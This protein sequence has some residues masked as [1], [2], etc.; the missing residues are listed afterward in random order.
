[1]SSLMGRISD[2]LIKELNEIKAMRKLGIDK[3]FNR[4][5]S[6]E[7]LTDGIVRC[8]EWNTIKKKLI[9]EPRKEDLD[10]E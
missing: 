2:T 10:L 9:K 8:L 4:E 6:N 3:R 7:K 1:M 5:I